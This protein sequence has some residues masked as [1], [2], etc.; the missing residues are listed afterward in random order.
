MFIFILY[1]K[2]LTLYLDFDTNFNS[3]HH[4]TVSYFC[5]TP[6]VCMSITLTHAKIESEEMGFRSE[7]SR[8]LPPV[9]SRMPVIVD[10]GELKV[11]ALAL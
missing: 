6:L 2:R 8:S 3:H 1:L 10:A 9:L 11:R 7:S 5:I 4:I